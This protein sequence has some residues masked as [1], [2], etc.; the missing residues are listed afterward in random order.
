MK[1]SK[2]I[3]KL[4]ERKAFIIVKDY[5]L[6]DKIRDD[7]KQHGVYIYDVKRPECGKITIWKIGKKGELKSF[8][9]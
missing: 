3:E 5:V 6:A 7:L 1:E 2:I 4:K 9:W 8:V